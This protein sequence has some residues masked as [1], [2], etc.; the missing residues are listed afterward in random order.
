V[1]VD[2][3]SVSFGVWRGLCVPAFGILAEGSGRIA[4]ST[5]GYF[6]LADQ[7]GEAVSGFVLGWGQLAVEEQA[8]K[9]G[10]PFGG[11]EAGEGGV[12]ETAD[13]CGAAGLD[14]AVE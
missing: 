10:A 13:F 9:L 1:V 4:L 7:D 14:E 12:P 3:G 5:D 2:S 6:V 8:A 11:A